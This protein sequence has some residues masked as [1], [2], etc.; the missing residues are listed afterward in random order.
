MEKLPKPV[1]EKPIGEKVVKV[2]IGDDRFSDELHKEIW[3]DPERF[4]GQHL[5]IIKPELFSTI[6]SN[7]RLRLLRALEDN[8]KNM[9]ELARMLNR[10]REAV[11]RDFKKLQFHGLVGFERNGKEKVPSRPSEI[12][13]AV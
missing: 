4:A 5:V 12:S 3:K 11:S 1:Y 13:I 9:G 6:L 10:P 8:P 7:E 2:Y